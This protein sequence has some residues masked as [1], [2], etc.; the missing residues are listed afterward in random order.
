MSP[1]RLI[2]GSRLG[3]HANRAAAAWIR[4]A[5]LAAGLRQVDL[6]E[7]L[8]TGKAWVSM[9]ET[10]MTRIAFEEVERIAEALGVPV[11][12]LPGESGEQ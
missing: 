2:Q 5:R 6:G 11:P 8:G 1:V 7:R 12:E 4:E 3:W 10:G 9:R